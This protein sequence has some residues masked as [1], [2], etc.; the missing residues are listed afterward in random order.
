MHHQKC[1]VDRRAVRVKLTEKG[2][3]VRMTVAQLFARHASLLQKK[4]ILDGEDLGDI[5]TTMRRVERFWSDQ[6]RFIY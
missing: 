4:D 5:N 1:A 6:I 2:R 3:D